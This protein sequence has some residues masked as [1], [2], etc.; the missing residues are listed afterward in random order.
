MEERFG[1]EEIGAENGKK[2]NRTATGELFKFSAF[3][4]RYNTS[5]IYMVGDMPL[6]M[7][8]EWSIP[9]FLICGG[10]TE[11]LAFIN[12]WFSSG[13]TKSV[14]HTDSMENFHCVVS[15]HK[16]FVMFEPL[17]SEA[18]GPEHKNLGY[19]HIDVGT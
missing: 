7:Q 18:I 14:L 12:V 13:G 10:Y 1:H 19:Y 9:S 15:G 17:Y 11:N 16:V 4:D 3:L 6:S 5:D 8:E 2:E